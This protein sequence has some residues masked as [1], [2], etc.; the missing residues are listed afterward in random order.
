VKA[1][2]AEVTEEI[3]RAPSIAYFLSAGS[4]LQTAIFAHEALATSNLKLRFE[5]PI[6]YLYSHSIELTLKAFLRSSG[7]TAKEL[8]RREWGHDL[9]KLWE[10]CFDRG[11]NLDQQT[12]LMIRGVLDLLAFY[13]T[14]YEF[15]YVQVGLKT[16][17]TLEA[18]REAAEALQI[19]IK[20]IA[21][22]D[23]VGPVPDCG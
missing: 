8:T 4:F 13:A 12:R 2:T 18:V 3:D 23:I 11:F 20:P 6:Y 14:T 9:L 5:M 17:P 16:L 7:L 22:A 21:E 1:D 19:A 15:R 10:G